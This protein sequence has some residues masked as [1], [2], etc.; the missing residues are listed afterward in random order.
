[1]KTFKE[2]HPGVDPSKYFTWKETLEAG[3]KWK[4]L[5]KKV[6]DLLD[7]YM[8]FDVEKTEATQMYEWVMKE[9]WAQK[10]TKEDIESCIQYWKAN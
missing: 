10:E 7:S 6:W 5:A 8:Y 3:Q 1:M 4:E 9:E 2:E